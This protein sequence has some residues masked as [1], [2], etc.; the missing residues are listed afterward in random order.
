MAAP[1]EINW[2][3]GDPS[4]R[5]EPLDA[6]KDLG[7]VSEEKPPYQY[8]NWVLGTLAEWVTYLN[9]LS[10]TAQGA[11]YLRSN[12]PITYSAGTITLVDFLEL[13]FRDGASVYT[14]RIAAGTIALTDG[15]VLV[16]YK[17]TSSTTVTLSS[18]TYGTLAAGQYAVVAESS[19]SATN[20][21]NEVILF[22][23]RAVSAGDDTYGVGYDVI[24]CPVLGTQYL[25]GERFYL[26]GKDYGDI[27]V[28]DSKDINVYSGNKTGLVFAVDG[29][30]GNFGVVSGAKF[31]IDGTS[32]SG[33][34]YI[35]ESA[36]DVM[37][38]VVGGNADI[39]F[40][41]TLVSLG[42]HDISVSPTYKF[43]FDGAS[44]TFAY[45]KSSNLFVIA[46]AGVDGLGV[47]GGDGIGIEPAKRFYFDGIGMTGNTYQHQSS[48]DVYGLVVGGT[49]MLQCQ[50]NGTLLT[51]IYSDVN[52]PAT[53]KF[54]LDG[55][56][57]TYIY[58]SSADVMG[59]V[60]GGSTEL[61][62]NGT[63]AEFGGHIY[64]ATN[65]VLYLDGGDD[66]GIYSASANGIFLKL[67][68]TDHVFFNPSG[69][70]SLPA[71]DPP[72]ANFA[73]SNSFLKAWGRFDSTGATTS[74]Y[75]CSCTYSGAAATGYTVTFG[76]DFSSANYAVSAQID[77]VAGF[78][79]V[80][81]TVAGSMNVILFDTTGTA[82]T[83]DFS[84]M[85]A[86]VQ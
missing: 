7:W 66:T 13:R 57:N 36:S 53:Y 62:I 33:N 2:A 4:Y 31:F 19:L 69:E 32:L 21:E 15:Q 55:G 67:G 61:N 27:V 34:S 3:D 51:T 45:E 52:V 39:A 40:T 8:F 11:N 82:M 41:T 68:G 1:D 79:R 72:T 76:T 28:T 75:N 17:D 18:G 37:R 65:N 30:T 44:D 14:N 35:Y 47:S 85:A 56:S 71:V 6:K 26:G 25:S 42:A 5:E 80:T 48:S 54:Y 22:R 58:E 20:A 63:R 74:A 83:A 12:D 50:N 29:A 24:E 60:V 46:T 38:F 81:S 78:S 49:T 84:V 77:G 64:V 70:M 43:Y 9:D 10:T 59:F 73:N 23:R 86:G 16:A